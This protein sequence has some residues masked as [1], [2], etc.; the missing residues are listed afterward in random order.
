MARV[1]IQ[2]IK[3]WTILDIEHGLLS[4]PP[5]LALR[6]KAIVQKFRAPRRFISD[7]VVVPR[8]DG[9]VTSRVARGH[10]TSGDTSGGEP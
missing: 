10:R 9:P 4:G 3:I 1:A 2:Y 5:V 8:M 7:G 6:G